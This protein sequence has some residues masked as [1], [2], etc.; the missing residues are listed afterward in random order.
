MTSDSPPSTALEL[1]HR[2]AGWPD[3]VVRRAV[4]AAFRDIHPKLRDILT[5]RWLAIKTLA[6][7]DQPK[8]PT[9]DN[10]SALAA[11]VTSYLTDPDLVPAAL[12][13]PPPLTPDLVAA[14]WKQLHRSRQ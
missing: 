14:I 1:R 8:A 5:G 13:D 11:F 3:D 12:N 7:A 6:E 2:C 10:S 4:V 9:L